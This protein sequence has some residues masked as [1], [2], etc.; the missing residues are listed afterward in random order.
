M[1]DRAQGLIF[2]ITESNNCGRWSIRLCPPARKRRRNWSNMGVHRLTLGRFGKGC[3]RIQ[4]IDPKP[5]KGEVL[6]NRVH[7]NR[8]PVPCQARYVNSYPVEIAYLSI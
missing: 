3:E 6:S 8:H 1:F 7:Q 4:E 2:L 5:R